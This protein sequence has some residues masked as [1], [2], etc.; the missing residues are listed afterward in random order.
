MPQ[1]ENIALHYFHVCCV[2]YFL[3]FADC[4]CYYLAIVS[5]LTISLLPLFAYLLYFILNIHMFNV[6]ARQGLLAHLSPLQPM[7]ANMFYLFSC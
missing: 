6:F 3:S 1:T 2:G 7:L 5:L 4:V